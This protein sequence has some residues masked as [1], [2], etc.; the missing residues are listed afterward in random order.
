MAMNSPLAVARSTS[1]MLLA[2]ARGVADAAAAQ[3]RERLHHADDGAQQ[4]D[5]G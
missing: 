2:S 3:Y 5:H 4:P 1:P